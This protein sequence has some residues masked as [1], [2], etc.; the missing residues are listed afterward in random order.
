MRKHPRRSD[1][2][3]VREQMSDS[4]RAICAVIAGIPRGK[5]MTYGQVAEAAGLRGAARL[6]GYTLRAVGRRVPWQRVLGQ[7]RKGWAQVAIKDP[8]GGTEQRVRLERE[9]VYF[10]LSGGVDLARYGHVPKATGAKQRR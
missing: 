7:R 2:D 6:V 1:D 5:V 4:Y 10:S 3:D 8:I 9:G